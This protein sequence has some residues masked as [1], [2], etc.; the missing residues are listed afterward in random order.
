MNVNQWTPYVLER[1]ITQLKN[2]CK[3]SVYIIVKENIYE[4]HIERGG[5]DHLGLLPDKEYQ[6]A[7]GVEYKV[8][9][10]TMQNLTVRTLLEEQVYFDRETAE[11]QAAL[12]QY[13]Y[14]HDH[15]KE[16]KNEN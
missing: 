2:C 1:L 5:Y 15:R 6:V 3:N 9:K 12:L 14:D 10:Y 4:T 11:W 7:V 13:Q 16:L 8:K